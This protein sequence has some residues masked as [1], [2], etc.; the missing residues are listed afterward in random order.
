MRRNSAPEERDLQRASD[1]SGVP[2]HP[3]TTQSHG[4][5]TESDS[6]SAP[7][8]QPR[9][10]VVRGAPRRQLGDL[11]V[12]DLLPVVPRDLLSEQQ[13]RPPAGRGVPVDPPSYQ[14]AP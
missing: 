4:R 7:V 3:T 12:V 1:G 14:Y 9:T 11:P 6:C 10:L 2:H 8:P 5:Q 13:R